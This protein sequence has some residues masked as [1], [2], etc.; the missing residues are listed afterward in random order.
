MKRILA[1]AMCLALMLTSVVIVSA[2]VDATLTVDIIEGPIS[3]GEDVE[4]C[5]SI[6]DWANAYA[7]IELV[8][9]YDETLLELDVIEQSEFSGA[10]AATNANKFSLLCNP[11]S[12][13]QAKKLLGGE[14]CVAYFIA[15]EDI[16]ESTL[17]SVTANVKGYA[18]GEG[19]GWVANQPLS[20]EIVNGGIMVD[21]VWPPVE[22]DLHE[23]TPAGE[24]K[25]DET[26]HWYE[27]AVGCGN[28]VNVAPHEGGEATCSAK[29]VCSVCNV[30][31]GSFAA[32]VHKNTEVKD[33]TEAGCGNN[34]YTGDTFCNDCETVIA[35]GQVIPATGAHTGGEASCSAKAVCDVCGTEY[36]ALA[37]NVHKNTKTVG[38]KG[39]DCGN[40][41]YTGDTV[42]NDCGKTIAYG[43]VIPSTGEHAGGEATCTQKA[44]CTGCGKEYGS[45]NSNNHK[46]T[47]A[48][49]GYDATCGE[50]GKGANT[51]CNDCKKVV[52]Y[53]ET[54]PA[55]GAH[56]GGTA[57]CVSKAV[58]TVCSQAYGE[59]NAEN[60]VGGTKVVNK[61]ATYSGDKQCNSCG[62]II[63]YGKDIIPEGE[64]PG[65][66]VVSDIVGKEGEEV[67]VTV[68]LGENTA[69]GSYRATLVY[70]NTA[71][72]LVGMTKG[73]FCASVNVEN[74]KANGFA[75]NDVTEGTLFTATFKILA[76]YGNHEVGVTFEKTVMVDLTPVTMNVTKGTVAVD[77]AHE[78]LSEIKYDETNHWYECLIGC[79]NLVNVAPHEG[80]EA[81]CSAK[82]KCTVC[83]AEYGALANDVHKNTETINASE[84]DNIRSASGWLLSLL[85]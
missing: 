77:C 76:K 38:A 10:M 54:I 4:V 18:Q 12:D 19:D 13:R 30:E 15:A 46:N 36:G 63:E 41:G 43:Q 80:G 35:K 34:G 75:I 11:S 14:I 7:V 72:E 84:A 53:G 73:D 16:T 59:F 58:C 26:N 45:V 83:G 44:I 68:S 79:G 32:D 9:E 82:A 51:Y 71:L 57:T 22:D 65:F 27:C 8:L 37:T 56:T 1:L 70:D 2:D 25:Y 20:V 66:A 6:T 50:D 33:A 29:A 42:C 61:T 5:I 3:A 52:S 78:E 69:L 85:Q 39:A 24:I 49:G 48:Q 47:V 60:H 64:N 74:G 28:L 40:N 62:V 81:T 17:V 21:D 23:C 55:T 31:Y 67:T